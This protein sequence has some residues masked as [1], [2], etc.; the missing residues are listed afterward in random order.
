MYIQAI[1]IIL[2]SL[3]LAACSLQ[4]EPS[5]LP[6]EPAMTGQSTPLP[7][8]DQPPDVPSTSTPVRSIG[9]PV[10]GWEN[11][12]IM[13]GAYDSELEDM[14]FLYRVDIPLDEVEE[15]YQIKLDVNGWTLTNRQD[16][17]VNPSG[18]AAILDFQKE[19][20]LLNI[21]LVALEEENT[22]AVI[23]SM[24]GP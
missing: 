4:A 1:C 8:L 10:P 15:Y 17:T 18:P 19:E 12:P 20:L 16:M 23:L 6:V 13:P 14:V 7:E 2:G 22:T 3:I 21:M 24:L 9:T 5:S 11:I